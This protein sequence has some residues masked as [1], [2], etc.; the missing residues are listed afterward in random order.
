ME[1]GEN[2]LEEA[3]DMLIEKGKEKLI[4]KGREKL[5]EVKDEVVGRGTE[6]IL[7]HMG[8]DDDVT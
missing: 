7:K 5:E 1:D 8:A 2:P 3:K 4:E 6:A